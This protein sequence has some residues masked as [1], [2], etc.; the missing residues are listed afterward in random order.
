MDVDV[1]VQARDLAD[2]PE[3]CEEPW[4]SLIFN[5]LPSISVSIIYR[6]TL[7]VFVDTK[8]ALQHFESV[9][10]P[11]K[12]DSFRDRHRRLTGCLRPKP[13][14]LEELIPGGRDSLIALYK[15]NQR[16]LEE[17]PFAPENS[18]ADLL[19]ELLKIP[20]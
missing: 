13:H 15:E 4:F 16:L 18:Y 12:R 7:V 2:N 6:E 14:Q 17:D 11:I 19:G 9:K 10:K 3:N 5:K 1:F 20:K 8:K